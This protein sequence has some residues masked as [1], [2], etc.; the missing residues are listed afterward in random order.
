[1]GSAG[2]TS[3]GIGIEAVDQTSPEGTVRSIR[4]TGC[5]FMIAEKPELGAAVCGSSTDGGPLV[6]I[7][8]GAMTLLLQGETLLTEITPEQYSARVTVASGGSIGMHYRHCL[9][10]FISLLRTGDDAVVDFDQRDR[11][12]GIETVPEQALA[13]TRGIRDRLARW[14]PAQLER[15]VG[16]RCEISY[17]PGIS[18]VTRS[19]LGRELAYA[20]AHAIHHFAIIAILA[21]LQGIQLPAGFGIA[22][23]TLTHLRLNPA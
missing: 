18:P 22:P 14:E 1:M 4:D 12:P 23:S 17:A 10:H 7:L 2:D 19:T 16:T 20:I 9:D 11:D 13:L 15:T 3:V 8:G 5:F 21:R 6:R